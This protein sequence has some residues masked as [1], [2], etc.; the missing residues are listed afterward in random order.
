MAIT[1]GF[2]WDKA[3]FSLYIEAHVKSHSW[4]V[5]AEYNPSRPI[6]WEL[7]AV[8]AQCSA[9]SRC[10]F[11]VQ[12]QLARLLVRVRWNMHIN[13]YRM[14]MLGFWPLSWSI[15]SQFNTCSSKYCPLR[16]SLYHC[17]KCSPSTCHSLAGFAVAFLAHFLLDKNTYPCIQRRCQRKGMNA[18]LSAKP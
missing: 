11:S 1:H 10:R 6:I 13:I 18:F 5:Q 12:W 15:W 17:S 16:S 7:G 4:L 8:S 3:M 2:L 9:R 14:F